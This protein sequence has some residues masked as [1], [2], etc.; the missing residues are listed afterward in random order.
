ME[1]TYRDGPPKSVIVVT[2]CVPFALPGFPRILDRH[3]GEDGGNERRDHEQH[4][5]NDG[6][7]AGPLELVNRENADEEEENG[8]FGKVDRRD[9]G[10]L[11]DPCVL[12]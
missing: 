8:D 4:A 2:Q 7:P 9:V 5:V 3:A 12:Q 6:C 11:R 1:V 10:Y